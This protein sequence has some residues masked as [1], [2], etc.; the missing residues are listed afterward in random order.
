[1]R[2]FLAAEGLPPVPLQESL[3]FPPFVLFFWRVTLTFEEE[4]EGRSMI[5]RIMKRLLKK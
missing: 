1:M 4:E 2:I 3:Y 5:S